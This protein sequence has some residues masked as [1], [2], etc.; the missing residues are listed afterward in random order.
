MI[1]QVL[2]LFLHEWSRPDTLRLVLHCAPLLFPI[3]IWAAIPGLRKN[4]GILLVLFAIFVGLDEFYFTCLMIFQSNETAFS[5]GWAHSRFMTLLGL[6]HAAAGAGLYVCLVLRRNEWIK[7][8][9][10][11]IGIFSAASAVTHLVEVFKNGQLSLLHIGPPLWHDI[12]LAILVFWVLNK[13]EETEA[14]V[15]YIPR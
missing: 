4:S 13:A 14:D 6:S 1:E 10:I 8:I 9:L 2:N 5:Y 7:G 3:L 15:F 11:L 12:L